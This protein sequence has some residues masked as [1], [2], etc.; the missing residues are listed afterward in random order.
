[1]RWHRRRLRATTAGCC[2][3]REQWTALN[4]AIAVRRSVDPDTP[5]FHTD[6]IK[7]LSV[8]RNL[9]KNALKFTATGHVTTRVGHRDG[10]HRIEVEDT[11]P[12][13]PPEVLPHIFYGFYRG[14][15]SRPSTGFGL[16]LF[17]VKRFVDVLGGTVTV[18]SAV[19]GGTR[20]VVTV[21]SQPD[22]AP[23]ASV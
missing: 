13:I 12:G 17:I 14:R 22:P 19:G 18:D 10:L 4:P 21:P 15:S 9:V 3:S 6:R 7:L 2:P 11:G 16:G 8:I 20:F 5:E 23:P 1:M